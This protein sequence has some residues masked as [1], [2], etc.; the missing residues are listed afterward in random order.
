MTEKADFYREN[1]GFDAEKEKKTQSD[2]PLIM[3]LAI[4]GNWFKSM[5]SYYDDPEFRCYEREFQLINDP[6]LYENGI[7]LVAGVYFLENGEEMEDEVAG[8]LIVKNR[9]HVIYRDRLASI[10]CIHTGGNV[11]SLEHYDE[12]IGDNPTN[13]N[14]WKESVALDISPEDHFVALTSFVA[15]I[16]EMGLENIMKKSYEYGPEHLYAGFNYYMHQQ[17]V[18]ALMYVCPSVGYNLLCDLIEFLHETGGEEWLQTRYNLLE[19]MYGRKKGIDSGSFRPYYCNNF[20]VFITLI[21]LFPSMKAKIIG[22]VTSILGANREI[23]QYIYDNKLGNVYHTNGCPKEI[24]EDFVR[25]ITRNVMITQYMDFQSIVCNSTVSLELIYEK[26]KTFYQEIPFPCRLRLA[27]TIQIHAKNEKI[28]IP[29]L[30][31]QL[32]DSRKDVRKCAIRTI[33]I[34]K[35]SKNIAMQAIITENP[36]IFSGSEEKFLKPNRKRYLDFNNN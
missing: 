15:S 27:M 26:I 4:G 13:F 8:K 6:N 34:I 14:F 25:S 31:E 5:K 17:F 16:V 3:A 30:Y 36:E 32:T 28:V 22:E 7:K 23:L 11:P 9:I 2:Y 29:L 19:N 18:R 10:D 33:K 21:E 1:F 24:L 35:R 12:T 20:R